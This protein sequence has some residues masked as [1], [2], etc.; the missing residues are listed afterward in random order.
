MLCKYNNESKNHLPKQVKPKNWENQS[1]FNFFFFVFFP[2]YFFPSLFNFFDITKAKA[3]AKARFNFFFFL[4]RALAKQIFF[5]LSY[6]KHARASYF[7]AEAKNT[8]LLFS[9]GSA[10]HEFCLLPHY[11]WS[12]GF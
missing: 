11:C 10:L 7:I 6:L 8:Y 9:P 12:F 1:I 4:T 2:F 5:N 3:K